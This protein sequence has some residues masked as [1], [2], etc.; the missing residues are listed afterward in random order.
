VGILQDMKKEFPKGYIWALPYDRLDSALLW[1]TCCTG[2]RC[3]EHQYG[4]GLD[5]RLPIPSWCWIAKGH[6][7]WFEDGFCKTKSRVTWHKPIKYSP[8]FD[9]NIRAEDDAAECIEAPIFADSNTPQTADFICDS[10]FLHFTAH[11]T[12]LWIELESTPSNLRTFATYKRSGPAHHH[13][14]SRVTAHVY[15]PSKREI[16]QIQVPVSVFRHASAR[17]C[18]F[19]LLSEY[20][21]EIQTPIDKINVREGV[22]MVREKVDNNIHNT[23]DI[24]ISHAEDSTVSVIIVITTKRSL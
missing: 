14:L 10:A 13:G 15:S 5:T 7:T 22:T 21:G 23:E 18:E 6:R 2:G 12:M 19:V 1:Q 16:G 9:S 8:A 20:T 11:T 24:T 17:V 3:A 4:P